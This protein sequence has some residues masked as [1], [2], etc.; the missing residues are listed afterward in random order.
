MFLNR[1]MLMQRKQTVYITEF[2][3]K[4]KKKKASLPNCKRLHTHHP[5]KRK[6]FTQQ[7]MLA[8]VQLLNQALI[9]YFEHLQ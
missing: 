7:R 1:A 4:K 3:H 5:C 6:R 9:T 8:N 2:R